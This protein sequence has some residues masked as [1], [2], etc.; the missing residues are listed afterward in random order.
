[1]IG[2]L[3]HGAKF[4]A[5]VEV[6]RLTV[7]Q[8]KFICPNCGNAYGGNPSEYIQMEEDQIFECCDMPSEL[9]EKVGVTIWKDDATV[10]GEAYGAF[11]QTWE[12]VADAPVTRA[13]YRAIYNAAHEEAKPA[14][15]R[16]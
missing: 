15:K 3:I 12:I 4:N 14:R 5:H 2:L 7:P 13:Q 16:K 6:H 8:F 1:M 10:D 9:A 11:L